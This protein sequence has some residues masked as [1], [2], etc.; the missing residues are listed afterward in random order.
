MGSLL[1]CTRLPSENTNTMVISVTSPSC[2]SGSNTFSSYAINSVTSSPKCNSRVLTGSK[3]QASVE[4]MMVKL[5]ESY[6]GRPYTDFC[7]MC[8]ILGLECYQNEISVQKVDNFQFK[9]NPGV[10]VA[11]Y[12][13][14]PEKF[15]SMS[16]IDDVTSYINNES[17]LCIIAKIEQFIIRCQL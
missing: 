3:A 17:N 14:T 8:S 12:L 13:T 6:V 4:P 10:G 5:A 15:S 7:K 11:F 2:S 9:L 1:S 16:C